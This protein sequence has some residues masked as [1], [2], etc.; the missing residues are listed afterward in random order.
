MPAFQTIGVMVKEIKSLQKIPSNESKKSKNKTE[1]ERK[2]DFLIEK[3]KD[4]IREYIL[5]IFKSDINKNDN[6]FKNILKLVTQDDKYREY[7]V[8]LISK[9]LSK[10]VILPKNSFDTLFQLIYEILLILMLLI[11]APDNLYKDA[12]LLVKSTMNYGKEEKSKVLTI[13]DLCKKKLMETPFIY[14]QKFWNE[15]Y[16]FE[17]NNN[18][19]LNG[20]L[21]NDVKNEA[22]VCISKT[23]K[24]LNI[25][26][27]IIVFYTNNL[28]KK[29]FDKD[30]DLIH[31]TKKDILV[32]I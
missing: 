5:K 26:N 24:E 23:M 2:A 20:E 8:K 3:T 22:M 16:I 25:D 31:E 30:L 12:V 21:L 4:Q 32:C 10:V 18:M 11:E 27:S 29:Y 14:E 19:N 13:W 28:M 6:D 15:W 17:I 7:F 9:N 1:E